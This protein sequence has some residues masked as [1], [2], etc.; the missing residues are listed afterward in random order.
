ML[1]KPGQKKRTSVSMFGS[2]VAGRTTVAGPHKIGISYDFKI[3]RKIKRR[4][5]THAAELRGMRGVAA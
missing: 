2:L 4:R 5:R 1:E 3:G